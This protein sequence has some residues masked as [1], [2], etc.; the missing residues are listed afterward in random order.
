MQVTLTAASA[1]APPAIGSTWLI[2]SLTR[3]AVRCATLDG[4]T[5]LVILSM[6]TARLARVRSISPTSAFGPS[7]V[8][9][10]SV[11]A[12]GSQGRVACAGPFPHPPFS[13]V[14]SCDPYLRL[15]A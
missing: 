14:R 13:S 8:V 11:S 12:I 2:R 15:P 10:V 7:A 5:R 6:V 1:M 3:P 9:S 4:D